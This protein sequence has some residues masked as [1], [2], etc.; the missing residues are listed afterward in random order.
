M[1][2]QMIDQQQQKTA[3]TGLEELL[4]ALSP[5]LNCSAGG[6]ASARYIEKQVASSH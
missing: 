3:G 5:S 2:S 1:F 4:G 6:V